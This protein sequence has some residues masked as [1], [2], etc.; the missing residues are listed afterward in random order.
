MR[1]YSNPSLKFISKILF[2]R[3]ISLF[4]ITIFCLSC[5]SHKGQTHNK[6]ENEVVIKSN[7]KKIPFKKIENEN[8]IG[9]I[10]RYT[11][12]PSK[13]VTPRTID[14]WLPIDYSPSKKY[15]VLYMNDGQD[16]FDPSVDARKPEME[17]DETITRLVKEGKLKN[18]IAIGIYNVA[19][20]RSE[21]YLPQKPIE[22]LPKK[23]RDSMLNVVRAFDKSFK[24]NS[25][26]Y[27]KFLT[28]EVKPYID[29][30]YST[31]LDFKETYIGGASMGGLISMYAVCEYPE[32][33]GGAICM[34]THWV[35]GIPTPGN[36]LPEQFFN[37]IKEN[38]PSPD[39]HKFYF[40]FG[41][42]GLDR[43][44][45]QYED[46]VNELFVTN[47]FNNSGI[48]RNIK[49]QD[50][51]HNVESWRPRFPDA[52]EMMLGTNN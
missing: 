39:T 14:V 49:F 22:N 21:D 40:D 45:T 48:F 8:I 15:S 34:S 43:Y 35:G 10:N 23:M 16:L 38:L 46:D 9:S 33:F 41:T 19:S 11:S 28:Q 42:N 13:Y 30:T 12:F 31:K 29:A 20:D 3:I 24:I 51:N 5:T 7:P 52:L 17:I 6:I 27:L 2:M 36:P 18:T 1:H 47:G 4:L 32:T 37:Y 25:D 26:N 50:G 44:Y